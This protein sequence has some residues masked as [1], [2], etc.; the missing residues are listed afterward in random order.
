MKKA[1]A[2]IA[3]VIAVVSL[4]YFA[5]TSVAHNAA[6]PTDL[7]LLNQGSSPFPP[8]SGYPEFYV[9]NLQGGSNPQVECRRTGSGGTFHVIGNM[10]VKN[11]QAELKTIR[12]DAILSAC[13]DGSGQN[14][15]WRVVTSGGSTV[16]GTTFDIQ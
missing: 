13:T 5:N 4:S 2:F 1:S 9:G 12:A 7:N 3:V 6:A 16:Y 14:I 10:V 8:T 11:S 15:E